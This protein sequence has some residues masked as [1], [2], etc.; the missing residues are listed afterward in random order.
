MKK[1]ALGFLGVMAVVYGLTALKVGEIA[2]ISSL[3]S[4]PVEATIARMGR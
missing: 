3:R 4:D 1:A 2:K